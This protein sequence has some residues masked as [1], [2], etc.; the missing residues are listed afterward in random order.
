MHRGYIKIYRKITENRLWNIKPFS[1]IQAFIDLIM[2]A[3][4]ID[5][6]VF[7][8]DQLIE[9]KRGQLVT[10]LSKLS[11]KWGWSRHKTK[12]C[13]DLVQKLD[14]IKYIIKDK[15]F[16][17]ITICNYDI[18]NPQILS[19]GQVKGQVKGQQKDNRRT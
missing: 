10:S 5:K 13:L 4:H 7:F 14:S 6:T 16:M 11:I 8:R 3:N 9:V 12:T 2:M 15:R 1:K 17:I 18:Y 19:E